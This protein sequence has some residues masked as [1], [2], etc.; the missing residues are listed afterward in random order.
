VIGDEATV[1][2]LG[3]IDGKPALIPSNPAYAPII[4]NEENGDVRIVGEVVGLIRR[5]F[6]R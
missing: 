3:K 2:R 1:K 6:G 4:L 5:R